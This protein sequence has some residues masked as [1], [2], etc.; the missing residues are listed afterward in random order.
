MG[1]NLVEYGPDE[2][3]ISRCEQQVYQIYDI[4]DKDTM[5]FSKT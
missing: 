4:N 1:I 3:I 2:E 5:V